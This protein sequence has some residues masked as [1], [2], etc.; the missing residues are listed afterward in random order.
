MPRKY[1][2]EEDLKTKDKRP[3]SG[4][5]ADLL[6]CLMESDCV[7]K[8]RKTPKDCLLSGNNPRVPIECHQLRQS[9]FECKKSLIDNRQ[10]F[11]GRKGY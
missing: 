10:R 2:E 4:L 3:C 9:F 6:A 7:Q 11:R 8:D 5:R 1:V